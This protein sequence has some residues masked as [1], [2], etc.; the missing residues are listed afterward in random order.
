MVSRCS[1]LCDGSDWADRVRQQA[2]LLL[3][4]IFAAWVVSLGPLPLEQARAGLHHDRRPQRQAVARLRHGR[5]PLAA[6]GRCRKPTSTRRY[7]KL[8]LAYEDRR[9]RSHAGVDPLALGRA[10]FQLVTR[11]HIVSG[12]STITMQLA[13]LMEPRRQRSIYAKLRQMVRALEIERQMTKD[14]IL[15]LYLALAP[16]AAISRAFAPPRSPISARSRSDCRFRKRR[17]W[18]RCRNRRKPAGSIAI[19]MPRARRATAC[20]TAWS[21][22]AGSRGKTRQQAKAAAG[23]ADAQ[24]DADPGAA[25]RRPGDRDRQG[26]RSSSS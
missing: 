22:R 11:G 8:L 1:S 16:L 6:A 15:N 25:F 20:S 2:G 17:C 23:A 10:A 7:L 24:A 14:Q 18:W 9:F 12:G 5:R 26:C 3:A 13:R 21:R 19:L 4:A